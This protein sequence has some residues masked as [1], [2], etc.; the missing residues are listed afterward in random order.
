LGRREAQEG[1]GRDDFGA[2]LVVEIPAVRA[3]VGEV[4][5]IGEQVP[6]GGFEELPVPH[7]GIE[8]VIEQAGLGA[9]GLEFGAF[10]VSH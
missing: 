5:V 2:V 9:Q 7:G 4:Q 3:L 10:V 8:R 1:A 6:Q